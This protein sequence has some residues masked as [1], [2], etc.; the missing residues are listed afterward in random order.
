MA[1]YRQW[2]FLTGKGAAKEVSEPSECSSTCEEIE[3]VLT[4]VDQNAEPKQVVTDY[5]PASNTIVLTGSQ[6]KNLVKEYAKVCVRDEF[7]EMLEALKVERSLRT[8]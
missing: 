6:L 5:K 2:L 8:Q 1:L 4:S 3:Q 7:L